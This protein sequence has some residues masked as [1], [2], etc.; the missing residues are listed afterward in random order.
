M[1]NPGPLLHCLPEPNSVNDLIDGSLASPQ[2]FGVWFGVEVLI[3]D[4]AIQPLAAEH[5]QLNV[6][7]VQLPSLRV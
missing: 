6:G 5:C 4:A 7:C 2:E 1:P 3:A